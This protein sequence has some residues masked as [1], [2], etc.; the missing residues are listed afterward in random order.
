MTVFC[1]KQSAVL[2][3]SSRVKMQPVMSVLL[4]VLLAVAGPSHAQ[5]MNSLLDWT[6][7]I[8]SILPGLS[9]P[10]NHSRIFYAV[11]F[12]AGSTG[13]RIHVYTFIQSDSG[14]TGHTDTLSALLH[15]HSYYNLWCWNSESADFKIQYSHFHTHLFNLH[16]ICEKWSNLQWFWYCLISLLSKKTLLFTTIYCCWVG[17]TNENSWIIN[18]ILF[19]FCFVYFYFN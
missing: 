13:T 14:N 5:V 3:W 16:N 7:S 6:N 11:M 18:V 12:D 19:L 1:N 8:R 15:I 4:L 9:R 10:A 2:C 17:T